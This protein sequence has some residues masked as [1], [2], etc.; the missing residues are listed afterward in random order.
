M[1]T[2]ISKSM[3]PNAPLQLRIGVSIASLGICWFVYGVGFGLYL[4]DVQGS[5]LFFIW[6]VPFFAMGW[7]LWGIPAIAMGNRILKIPKILLGIAGAIAGAIITLAPYLVLALIVNG[8]VDL[9]NWHS[10]SAPVSPLLG[11]G[12]AAGASGT[13]LYAWFLSREANRAILS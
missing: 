12:S 4:R 11:F 6:S 7:F 13:V 3:P 1:A 2:E 10:S 8:T 9:S 5:V